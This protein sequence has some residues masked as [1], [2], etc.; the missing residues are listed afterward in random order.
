V[1]RE[2]RAEV[3]ARQTGAG[4][5]IVD[6]PVPETAAAEGCPARR[7]IGPFTLIGTTD[8]IPPSVWG[9]RAAGG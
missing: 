8:R 7:R 9:C 1:E 5:I 2:A 3:L 4:L 6:F